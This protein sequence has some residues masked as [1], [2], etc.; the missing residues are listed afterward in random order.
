MAIYSVIREQKKEDL[1]LIDRI[2]V[3][4]KEDEIVFTTGEDFQYQITENTYNYPNF[5]LKYIKGQIYTFNI[6]PIDDGRTKQK[7]GSRVKFINPNGKNIGA[8]SLTFKEKDDEVI[9]VVSIYRSQQKK[10]DKFKDDINL[11]KEHKDAIFS[12]LVD[13]PA[14]VK[15]FINNKISLSEFKE[16]IKDYDNK[17]DNEKKSLSKNITQIK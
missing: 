9:A 4:I 6:I 1:I 13:Q 12:F 17:S 5:K 10:T 11:T 3:C 2:Q 15:D 16:Y 8:R 14:A 7:H